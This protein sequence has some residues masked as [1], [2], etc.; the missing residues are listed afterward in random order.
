MGTKRNV[1]LLAS[2]ALAVLLLCAGLAPAQEDPTPGR[3]PQEGVIPGRYIVV[4]EEGVRDPTAVAQEHAR[5]HGAEVLRTYRHAIKGYAARLPERRLEEVRA[6]GRVAYVE[7]DQ[8]THTT[9]Q[10]IPWGIDKIGADGSSARAG[11]GSGAVSNVNAYVIDSGIYKHADLRVVKHVNFAGDGKNYDCY[12]HGTHVAGSVAAKDNTRAVVGAAPGAPLTGVKVTG[13]RGSGTVSGA[14]K[15]IDWVTANAKKPAIANISLGTGVSK[16]LDNAVTNSAAG[17]VFYTIAA[18]NE[19]ADACKSSPARAGAG[20]DNGV[21]TVAAT[22]KRDA[23]PYWSNYGSCV[24]IWAPGAGILSTKKGGGT[25]KMS[26]T[27]MAAPHVGGGAALYLSKN[28]T[29]RPAAVEG[30]LTSSATTAANT[31]KD[32]ATIVR[33]YVGGF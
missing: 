29:A 12:G 30:A 1:L 2:T 26:G 28:T 33:E 9:A 16:S 6:D 21:A 15:G 27:S 7:R 8:T 10:T 14:I 5:G 25:T 31:S 17:G 11:N 3:G 32:G 13:C 18:G 23:E 4:L 24:D 19:G 20:T 22:N